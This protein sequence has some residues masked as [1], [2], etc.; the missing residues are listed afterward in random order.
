MNSSQNKILL[1]V[2]G[3]GQKYQGAWIFQDAQLQVTEG[4]IVALLG[5][6]GVGKTTLFNIIAGVLTPHEGRVFLQGEDITGRAGHI[7]YML[8]KDLLIEERTVLDN[9][10]IPMRVRGMSK[11]EAYERASE[12]FSEFGLEGYEKLYPK[13]LSGGMRQRAALLRTYLTEASMVLLDEPFS[14]LDE[15]T[16]EQLY[17]FYIQKSR[18]LGL[19]TLLITHN[20]DEA[21]KLAHRIYIMKGRPAR[22]AEAMVLGEKGE[23]FHLTAEFL[24]AKKAL[25][26]KLSS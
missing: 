10:S 4:E 7:S 14:A 19:T 18:K 20:V 5:E 2:Q 1:E 6:S 23:D 15:T 12:L 26:A 11:R 22:V 16:K 25:R 13:A 24:E 17:E 8:Q 21:L 9:V 3:V